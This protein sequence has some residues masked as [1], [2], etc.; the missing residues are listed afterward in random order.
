MKTKQI[1]DL[2]VG[3]PVFQIVSR[4]RSFRIVDLSHTELFSMKCS[5]KVGPFKYKAKFG[6]SSGPLLC[7][8]LETSSDVRAYVH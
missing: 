6:G 8:L 2:D 7:S 1:I 5:T 3:R 4:G